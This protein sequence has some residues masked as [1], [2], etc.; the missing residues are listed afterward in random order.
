MKIPIHDAIP[1]DSVLSL[2]VSLWVILFQSLVHLT[3]IYLRA[4]SAFSL[5][6]MQ[7]SPF[8]VFILTFV[9]DFLVV[10]ILSFLFVTCTC[11]MAWTHTWVTYPLSVGLF[12]IALSMGSCLYLFLLSPFSRLLAYTT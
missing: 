2:F 3:G 11:V 8:D 4:T 6:P 7:I 12:Q 9:D 10:A 5:Y 1:S